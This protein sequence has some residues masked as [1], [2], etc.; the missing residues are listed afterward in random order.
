MTEEQHMS[1]EG[2]EPTSLQVRGWGI[3]ALFTL[4]GVIAYA[5]RLILGALFVPLQADLGLSASELGILQG[6]S[7]AIVYAV[8]GLFIGRAADLWSRKWL[9]ATG[10]L[11][12]SLATLYCGLA[13]SFNE[14]LIARMLVG[15]GEATMA[16]CILS[17]ISDIFP[18][19]KRGMA[20]GAFNMGQCIGQG[21]AI[22]LGSL[23]LVVV[24]TSFFLQLPFFAE[25]APWRSVLVIMGLA[26]IPFMFAIMM[27]K[28]PERE[29][30]SV[31][32]AD[33]STDRVDLSEAWIIFRPILPIYAALALSNI[34]DFAILSWGPLMLAERAGA[35]ADQL[36][37][38]FGLVVMAT[39]ATGALGGGLLSDK[40]RNWSG[41]DMRLLSAFFIMLVGGIFYHLTVL[42][43]PASWFLIS[44]GLWTVCIQAG[45]SI[46]LAC[47]LE[48]LPSRM[49]G[50]ASSLLLIFAI[51]FGLT[52]GASGP[53]ILAD[54]LGGTDKMMTAIS[55]IAIPSWILMLGSYWIAHK[56]L[57]MA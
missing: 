5:D 44:L 12:W 34:C 11:V 15:V 9:L 3:V 35:D 50:I 7:F 38:T 37:I 55:I 4:V 2:S 48:P 28:E 23:L 57:K 22:F 47:L 19:S 42:I 45:F 36:S 41:R 29:V 17:L 16:P 46:A 43:A 26:S 10:L 1:T 49:R 56:R 54:L 53:G 27:L 40:M 8:S 13:R 6:A 21:S 51:G 33:T 18:K 32:G 24:Q 39:A 52:L 30:V 31:P 25:L 14:L 20:L